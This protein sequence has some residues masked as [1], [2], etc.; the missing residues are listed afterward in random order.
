MD[1]NCASIFTGPG[2]S[3]DYLVLVDGRASDYRM[4]VS[5]FR[6]TV[7]GDHVQAAGWHTGSS[8][9]YFTAMLGWRLYLGHG[10]DEVGPAAL[11]HTLDGGVTW[12]TI[13]RLPW[14]GASFQFLDPQTGWAL[15]SLPW[16][17]ALVKTTDGG[18]TWETINPMLAP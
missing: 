3:I 15:V 9:Y 16:G 1:S 17:G 8:D 6:T 12:Q 4:A 11:Q 7:E 14:T 2:Y 10:M 18:L 5:G 13:A